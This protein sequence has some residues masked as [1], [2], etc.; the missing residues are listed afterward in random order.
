MLPT[1]KSLLLSDHYLM[2]AIENMLWR[3][4]K[5]KMKVKPTEDY[6]FEFVTKFRANWLTLADEEKDNRIKELENH[7]Q[8]LKHTDA[9]KLIPEPVKKL[10]E[11]ILKQPHE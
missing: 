10:T 9:F 1:E 6:V 2:D 3:T 4:R 7:I 11:E 8:I 5:Y